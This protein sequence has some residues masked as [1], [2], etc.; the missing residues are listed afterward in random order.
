MGTSDWSQSCLVLTV[1]IGSKKI[2]KED[3]LSSLQ[4]LPSGVLSQWQTTIAERMELSEVHFSPRL[5]QTKLA[6][7]HLDC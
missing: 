5:W 1:V 2:T 4:S 3:V 7:S 6:I